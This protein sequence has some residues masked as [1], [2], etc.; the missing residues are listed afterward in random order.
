MAR[1]SFT[2][3]PEGDIPLVKIPSQLIRE[4]F[5]YIDH[6]GELKLV[7]NFFWRIEQMEGDFRYLRYDDLAS[8]PEFISGLGKNPTKILAESLEL[9]IEHG[10]LLKADLKEG[11]KTTA[12]YFVNSPRGRAAVQAIAQGEWRP[13]V[14]PATPLIL[15]RSRP[16][17]FQLY[18][19][20]IG[21]LTPML[22]EALGE[23][24]DTYPEA[25]IEDAFNIAAKKN[26]RNWQYISAILNR[27]QQEGRHGREKSQDR[28]NAEKDRRR[29]VDGEFADVVEH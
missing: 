2:G 6:L 15:T 7:L 17:I 16:N 11:E 27:W 14:P 21:P 1:P 18:E 13:T 28:P 20:H 5:P 12:L 23:A 3:F 24:Q 4:I 9:A 29:Y 19:E 22:A 25:W 8:D 26:K 10:I